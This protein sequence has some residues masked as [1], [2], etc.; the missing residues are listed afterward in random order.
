MS[1]LL[2]Q[3][4]IDV[5]FLPISS[6]DLNPIEQVWRSWKL[7]ASPLIMDSAVEY[8]ALLSALRTTH[9]STYLRSL[10]DQ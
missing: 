3:L 4:G 6:P 1:Y 10:L 7:E 8:R 5:V 2:H 9:N